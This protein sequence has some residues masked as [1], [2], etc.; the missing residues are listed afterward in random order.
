MGQDLYYPDGKTVKAV[1]VKKLGNECECNYDN[2]TYIIKN[3][4][5]YKRV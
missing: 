5:I 4:N 3:G 2:N 1:F